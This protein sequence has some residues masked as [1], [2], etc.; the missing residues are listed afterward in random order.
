MLSKIELTNISVLTSSRR[1]LQERHTDYNENNVGVYW[2][3]NALSGGWGR[4]VSRERM[5]RLGFQ[6]EMCF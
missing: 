5:V 1:R 6:V 4:V 2:E 3:R